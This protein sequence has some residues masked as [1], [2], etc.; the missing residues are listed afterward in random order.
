[1][2]QDIRR[3]SEDAYVHYDFVT[4][5]CSQCGTDSN[6]FVHKDHLTADEL[7]EYIREISGFS[8]RKSVDSQAGVSFV[9]TGSN[10]HNEGGLLCPI[11][12]ENIK[13]E[14]A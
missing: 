7:I 13:E 10:Y 9:N 1:M 2:A 4:V 11:C 3:V 12:A 8:V 6:P 14:V 5:K